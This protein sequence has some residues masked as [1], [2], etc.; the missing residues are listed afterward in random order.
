MSAQDNPLEQVATPVVISGGGPVGL[1]LAMFLD[2]FGV[3]S[4]VLNTQT[5]TRWQPKGS[6]HNARTMEHFRT[7]GISKDVRLLGLPQDYPTDIGYFTR[8]NGYELLRNVMPSEQEKVAAANAASV[9]DQVPEPIFRG[10]QMYVERFLHEHAKTLSRID[11][12]FGWQC[13][14][15]VD[16]GDHVIVT[17][18]EVTSGRRQTFRSLWLAGCD[19]AQ[20]IVRRQLGIN[21]DGPPNLVQ[22]YYG[23]PMLRTHF[24][25]PDFYSVVRGKPC[26]YYQTIN[27]ELRSN[28]IA[29]N[30]SDEFILGS[31]LEKAG[32]KPDEGYLRNL[33]WRSVGSEFPVEF[34]SHSNWT[35]GITVVAERYGYGRALLA[36]DSSHLFTPAGGF[37]M[38]TGIEDAVNLAWKIA[39]D[40]SGWGGPQLL[41]SYEP[42]RQPIGRR[43][44][45]ACRALNSTAGALKIAPNIESDGADGE[46]QRRSV[47]SHLAE[48]AEE[49]H[50][51]LGIQL[52]A[53]YD[54]SVIISHDGSEPPPDKAASYVPTA[55][56]GGR[57][58]HVWLPGQVSLFDCLGV[59]FTVLSLV[60]NDPRAE[61]LADAL[62][63][64]KVPVSVRAIQVPEAR[65]LYERDLA[66]I[67]PDQVI[68][69]R[70]NKLPDDITAL[71]MRVTGWSSEAGQS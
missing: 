11:L 44:T 58:P 64:R 20:G 17:A 41:A 38:N 53:R 61:A 43:N 30:G 28:I 23:G 26:L 66:L 14:G 18:E 4:V 29:L 25:A 9:L 45:A 33:L 3:S 69:W 21:Y 56:P 47:A 71:A 59:G 22:D 67:R 8:L 42:E 13:T 70:G 51:S 62:R 1:V 6:T 40:V 37:G 36:G 50:G 12:R 54:D 35:A 27:A 34:L 7:L 52:G 63:A 5:Q 55:C 65:E 31:R 39:A 2:R 49:M 68:A 46:E 15:F 60:G 24:R 10:N 48:T 32:D 16:N 19:G 57:A